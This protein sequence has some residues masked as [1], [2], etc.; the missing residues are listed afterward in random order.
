MGELDFLR[1][2]AGGEQLQFHL[3]LREAGVVVLQLRADVADARGFA[4][5][6]THFD[7][8][9]NEVAY[10]HRLSRL[11]GGKHFIVNTAMNG[12]GPRVTPTGFHVWC[13]PSGRALGPL[14]TVRTGDRLV[15]AF[16]WLIEPGL[17]SGTCRGGPH[18]GTFWQAWASQLYAASTGAPDF[19]LFARRR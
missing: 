14:P 5:N 15:D 6:A 4:L 1:L 17:S 2:G 10:G 12:R 7:W 8:T 19:P 16:F 13:N 3:G 18:V 9:S 11:V